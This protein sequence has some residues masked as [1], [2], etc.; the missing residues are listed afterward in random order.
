[1]EWKQHNLQGQD[2]A[3]DPAR[4]ID[5]GKE[6]TDYGK[7]AGAPPTTWHTQKFHVC[8]VSMKNCIVMSLLSEFIFLIVQV[9]YSGKEWNVE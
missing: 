8:T 2:G 3:D 7:T 6:E 5:R 4:A 9:W 1:M